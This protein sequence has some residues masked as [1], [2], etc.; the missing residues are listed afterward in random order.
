MRGVLPFNAPFSAEVIELLAD[1]FT[2]LVV[3]QAA[4]PLASL[5][6]HP[7]VVCSESS[8]GVR[9]L[10]EQLHHSEARGVVH[11][12]HPVPVALVCLLGE[13]AMQI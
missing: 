8:E 12:Q 11:K 9:L 5:C 7:C 10:P 2:T 4:Y 6:L 3:M 1:V 13:W